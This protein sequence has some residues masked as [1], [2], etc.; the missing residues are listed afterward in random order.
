VCPSILSFELPMTFKPA[1][2]Y[3]A[4]KLLAVKINDEYN[5]CKQLLPALVPQQVPIGSLRPNKM[6]KAITAGPSSDET[7]NMIAPIDTIMPEQHV[8]AFT[9]ASK[10][11]KRSHST[12]RHV[13]SSRRIT[14]RGSSCA[15]FPGTW[16]GFAVSP[17]RATEDH[18]TEI[19]G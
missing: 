17:H 18:V 10:S 14:P 19:V 3:V 5:H 6:R 13:P 16:V 1:H 8:S 15:S 9:N 2:G 4:V 12:K 7:T 11:R